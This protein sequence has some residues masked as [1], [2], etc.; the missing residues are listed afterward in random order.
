METKTS[1]LLAMIDNEQYVDAIRFAAKFPT[2]GKQSSDITR[3]KEA[4]NNPNFYRQMNKDPD[5]LVRIGIAA[6]RQRFVGK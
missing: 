3:A 1:Q 4:L 6:I 2:L 5:E